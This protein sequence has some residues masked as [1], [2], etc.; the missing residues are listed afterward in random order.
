MKSNLRAC[1]SK[2]DDRDSRLFLGL[3]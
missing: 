2:Y 3:L 1:D